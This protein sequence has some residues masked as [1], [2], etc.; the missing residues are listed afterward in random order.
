M[1]T[2][3]DFKIMVRLILLGLGLRLD[4]EELQAQVNASMPIPEVGVGIVTNL[5]Y[6]VWVPGL[7]IDPLR[8]LAECYKRRINQAP[9]SLRGLI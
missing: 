5:P 2:H 7:R 3:L 1:F 4:I 9:L 8:L 6:P